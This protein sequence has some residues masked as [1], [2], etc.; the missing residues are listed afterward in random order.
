M[1][2]LDKDKLVACLVFNG[3]VDD[4]K[5]CEFRQMIESCRVESVSMQAINS[6]KESIQ[7]CIESCNIIKNEGF[8]IE[9]DYCYDIRIATYKQCLEFIDKCMNKEGENADSD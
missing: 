3:L 4:M 2:L 8:R 5:C 9:P 1:A 6:I 7:E